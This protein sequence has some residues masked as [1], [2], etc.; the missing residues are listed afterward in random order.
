M[1]STLLRE[2]RLYGALGRRFGRVFHLAVST[3]AE[4]ARALCAVLPGF[5]REFVGP[6]GS[7]AYHV[8]VGRGPRRA[9]IGAEQKNDLV[10]SEEPIRIVPVIAGAK[11]GG[12][13]QTV[14]GV[15]LIAVGLYVGNEYLVK[16]GAMLVVSGVVQM[17][18]PQRKPPDKTENA[19]SYGMDAGALNTV[20]AGGPVPLAFGRVIA[21]SVQASAGL[22]TDQLL[23]PGGSPITNPALPAYMPGDPY[24]ETP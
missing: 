6:D 17:L 10:G 7:Q 22:S 2:V 24:R 20:D 21:G 5:K 1:N 16:A 4:A 13:L 14:I 12:V 15:V 8:F 3:P 9:A 18:S 11:R 23:A 19:P